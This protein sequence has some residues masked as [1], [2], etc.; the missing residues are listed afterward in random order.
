MIRAESCDDLEHQMNEAAKDG[1][2]VVG[3]NYV[4]GPYWNE[5]TATLEKPDLPP[6]HVVDCPRCGAMVVVGCE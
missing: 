1:W 2:R 6:E 3:T 5:Y 4:P